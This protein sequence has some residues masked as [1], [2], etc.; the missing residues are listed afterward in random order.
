MPGIRITDW[1][2]PGSLVLS[3]EGTLDARAGQAVK[4]RL[5]RLTGEWPGIRVAIELGG[6]RAIEREALEDLVLEVVAIRAQGDAVQ[7]VCPSAE[8]LPVLT[9]LNMAFST[10]LPLERPQV[11]ATV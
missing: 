3:L 10:R 4:Q 9:Q 11:G 8:C 6:I 1:I 5:A 7:L 2:A